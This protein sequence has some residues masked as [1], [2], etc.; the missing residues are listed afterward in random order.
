[1]PNVTKGQIDELITDIHT[2]E[3][4]IDENFEFDF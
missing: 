4:T 3:E 2:S 1:M